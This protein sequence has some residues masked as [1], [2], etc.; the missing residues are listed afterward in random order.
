MQWLIDMVIAAIGVPPCYIDR[1]STAAYDFDQTVLIQDGGWHDLDL[2][3]I[4]PENAKAVILHFRGLDA[5]VGRT[6]NVRPKNT[7]TVIGTCTV[8]NQV[9]NISIGLHATIGVGADRKIQYRSAAPGF[10]EINFLVRGW[11]L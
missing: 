5:A 1:G 4:I 9:A 7:T 11:I 2:S 3:G 8:R 6:L 10:A